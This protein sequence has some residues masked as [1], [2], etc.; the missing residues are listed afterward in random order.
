MNY[1]DWLKTV[2]VEIREDPLW[3][4][5]AYR[6]ALF[7]ADLGWHDITK[8]FRDGRTMKLAGQLFEAVGCVG[9]NISEGYSRGYQKVRARFYKYA[10]GPAR[11]S[12][13]WYF[14]GRFVLSETVALHRIQLHTQIIRLLL[15]MLPPTRGYALHDAGSSGVLGMH[16]ESEPLSA[17]ELQRLLDCVPMPDDE[18]TEHAA[19]NTNP[20]EHGTRSTEQAANTLLPLALLIT[21]LGCS[22]SAALDWP[23][24][25]GPTGDGSA[26][27]ADPPLAWSETNNVAWKS[28]RQVPVMSSPTPAGDD[29]YWV[30]DD[31]IATC[32]DARTV[33]LK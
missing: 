32:A 21:M 30:S 13:T 4:V 23:Q 18:L 5:E 14:D 31:G 2:P 6:L 25:R 26:P 28:P 33:Q 1:A 19:R 10:L 17:S 27:S 7:A 24:F 3:N 15:K 11:E 8:L 29:I 9:A 12:R 16:D 20:T 22:S